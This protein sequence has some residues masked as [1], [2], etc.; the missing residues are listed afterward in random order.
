MA[1]GILADVPDRSVENGN[2]TYT[3]A[4]SYPQPLK[5]SGALDSFTFEEATPVIGRE[6]P[7]LNIVDDIL[8]ADNADELLRDLAITSKPRN[9]TN[10]Q[11]WTEPNTLVQSPNAASSSSANKTISQTT[12]RRP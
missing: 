9:I 1:P 2:G 5:K 11:R 7:S 4:T 6:Y 12:S 8:N 10:R 3:K